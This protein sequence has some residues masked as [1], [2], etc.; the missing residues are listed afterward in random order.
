[1]GHEFPNQSRPLPIVSWRCYV[2]FVMKDGL[3][4]RGERCRHEAQLDERLH[5]GRNQKIENLIGI[6]EGIDQFI[7]L[8][9]QR[10]EIV[11]EQSMKAYP[12]EA[13]FFM[14]ALELLL[15]ICAQRNR[16]VVASY[17]IF[18]KMLKRGRYAQ[19]IAREF[20]LHPSHEA[21]QRTLTT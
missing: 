17:T 4:A 21:S 20:D 9:N 18:P 1:M 10:A 12:L 7:S 3:I 19:E 11:G 16:R 14:A 6:E 13:E 2:S 5:S 15:P 8:T